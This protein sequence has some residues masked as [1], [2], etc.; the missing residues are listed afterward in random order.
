MGLG[1]QFCVFRSCYGSQ[2]VRSARGKNCQKMR[3]QFGSQN[4]RK[5]FHRRRSYQLCHATL[6]FIRKVENYCQL[7]DSKRNRKYENSQTES[8]TSVRGRLEFCYGDKMET[9]ITQRGETQKPAS[10]SV[11][12]QTRTVSKDYYSNGGIAT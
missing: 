7:H 4:G 3:A 9:S 12:K 10:R 11:W 1:S 6:L 8:D 2:F 5:S